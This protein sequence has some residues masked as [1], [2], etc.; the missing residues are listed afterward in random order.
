MYLYIYNYDNYKNLLLHE[1][2]TQKL[3]LKICLKVTITLQELLTYLMVNNLARQFYF[4]LL[5]IKRK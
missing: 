3:N 2:F 1:T 5:K 4:D